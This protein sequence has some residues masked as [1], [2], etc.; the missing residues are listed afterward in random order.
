[1][2]RGPRPGNVEIRAD[3]HAQT[4]HASLLLGTEEQAARTG[5]VARL[6]RAVDGLIPSSA[7]DWAGAADGDRGHGAHHGGTVGCA[8]GRRPL[9][10]GGG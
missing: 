1:V 7:D 2:C 3:N 9:V 6:D 4:G 8:A 5:L 10:R